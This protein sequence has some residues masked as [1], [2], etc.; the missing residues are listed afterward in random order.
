VA[1]ALTVVGSAEAGGPTLSVGVVED[2]V[3]QPT[4]AEAKAKLTLVR[5]AGFDTD[6][7]TEVWVPGESVAPS[8]DLVGLRNAFVA[9]RALGMH[10]VLSVFPAGSSDTPLTDAARE[11][12][13]EFSLS[14][15][16]ALGV[17]E[18][19]VGNEPNLNRF[20][21]PQ[22]EGDSDAAAP[23]YE[24][25]L[26]TTY[27]ALKAFDP[28]IVVDGVAVSPRGIDR[29]GTRRDTHSPTAFVEDLG[30]ADR[31]SGR[32]RPIMDA[33]VIHPTRTTRVRRRRRPTRTRRR[34]RS[35][36]TPSSSRCSVAH[37]RTPRSTARRCR[38]STASSASR[39]TFRPT[40]PSCIRAWSRRRRS[41]V[42]AATQGRYYRDAIA[43]AFCQPTVRALFPLHAFDEPALAGWQSGLYY[44]DGTPKASLPLVRA[45]IDEARRGIIA[46]CPGLQLSPAPSRIVWPHDLRTRQQ[47]LRLQLACSIDCVYTA[48]SERLP[49]TAEVGSSRGRLVGGSLANLSLPHPSQPGRYRLRVSL[50]APV[51]PGP[52]RVLVGP[53]FAVGTQSRRAPARLRH[54]L[55]SK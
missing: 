38:S 42:D 13:A 30:A 1:V 18:L 50:V 25:L 47:P 9:A 49:S 22:V 55:G 31:A 15:A 17:H 19:V 2:A 14:L 10:M 11:Q 44:A 24:Q 46:R 23:A 52:P 41:P 53:A 39:R 51:N 40:R 21:L 28:H 34:S 35:P 20:W 12:F 37:S 4:V 7:V 27:D 43:L 45:A 36:T 32:T 3:K 54:A 26:A 6:N 5:Q 8:R 16:S 33:F 48:R 29:A